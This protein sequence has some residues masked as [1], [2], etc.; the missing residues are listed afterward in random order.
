M[1]RRHFNVEVDVDWL[2]S[3]CDRDRESPI[4]SWV[5]TMEDGRKLFV[6]AEWRHVNLASGD[7]HPVEIMD[8]SFG[9]QALSARNLVRTG[10]G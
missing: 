4:Y 1:Q 5:Y 6:L 9:I 8:M 7:G 2:D 3:H 10:T